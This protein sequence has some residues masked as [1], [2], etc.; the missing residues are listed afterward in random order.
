[1]RRVRRDAAPS[2]E[3]T[4]LLPPVGV[5][6]E[7]VL[8]SSSPS[9]WAAVPSHAGTRDAS[10]HRASTHGQG[11][12]ALARTL[13]GRPP[14]PASPLQAERWPDVPAAVRELAA[15]RPVG[16]VLSPAPAGG[17]PSIYAAYLGTSD[18][19][20]VPCLALLRVGFASR[21][22]R[23]GRWCALTAP[24]HPCLCPPQRAIGGLLSVALSFGSPRLAVSQHPAL[25]SPD[26]PQRPVRSTGPPRPPGRLAA[27]SILALGGRRAVAAS[28]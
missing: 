10:C 1:M 9:F 17:W 18:G 24:F 5:L 7:P 13:S 21:P 22:S 20:P 16:G 27:G 15:S 14:A 8:G 11:C 12:S 23:P 28:R 19:P 26:L 4:S 25:W 3:P 2:S 6:H